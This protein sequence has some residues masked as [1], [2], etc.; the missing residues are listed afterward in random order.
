MTEQM[1][2]AG[3]TAVAEPPLPVLPMDGTDVGS[4]GSRRK[5]IMVGAALAVLVLAVAAFFLT[6]G[7]SAPVAAGAVPQHHVVA[8]VVAKHH[9]AKANKPVTLPKKFKGHVGR[10]PFN[11][12]YVAPVAAAP[13]STGTS[14]STG[15]TD[16]TTGTTDSTTG[17]T[18]STTTTT[19]PKT[20][21][22]RPIWISLRK[23]SRTSATFAIGYSNH[24][25][26][27]VTKVRV[28]AP[29]SQTGTVFAKTF[30]LLD[31]NGGRVV[32][33]FGDGTPFVL[34]LTHNTMIVN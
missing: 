26:L 23:V 22:Y 3:G 24:H 18:D 25:T 2:P 27:R 7:G 29:K 12:L 32:V 34:D 16:S 14:G 10:D 13:S 5:L 8:P 21:I 17:T 4:A 6:K 30:S 33:Q 31:V 15:T 20:P 28:A 19:T 11:P 1:I 9:K